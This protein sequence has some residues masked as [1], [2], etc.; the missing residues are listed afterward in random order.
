MTPADDELLDRYLAGDLS[1]A[2]TAAF[3]ERLAE[4]TILR[5]RLAIRRTLTNF[6][7]SDEPALLDAL[8]DADQAY[9]GKAN[10]GASGGGPSRWWLLLLLLPLLA[11]GWYYFR[12]AT[13]D[14]QP[15][16]TTRSL[17]PVPAPTTDAPPAVAPDTPTVPAN[18][19]SPAEPEPTQPQ[20]APTVPE[21][22]ASEEPV[23][24]SADPAPTETQ[25]Y[26][27]LDPADFAPNPDL[28]E[29]IG[30][31][32]RSEDAATTLTISPDQDTLL[33]ADPPVIRI[34]S[35]VAPPYQLVVYGNDKDDFQA[36]RPVDRSLLSAVS[37]GSA[38]ST[39]Y[40]LD[41]LPGP[42]IYY[43]LLLDKEETEVLGSRRLLV[44]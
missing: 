31:T 3:E 25:V 33:L 23:A 43:V 24:P 4:D 44:R 16:S 38:Y 13:N 34:S 37:D 17:Q 8:A 18:N 2:E 11:A 1:A 36:G 32:V 26:A 30:L 42:G 35:P 10:D 41:G 12:P 6:L 29:L 9:Y 15:P 22:P 27:S 5:G 21:E 40:V 7:Q 14:A 39:T 19:P 20:P 28:E